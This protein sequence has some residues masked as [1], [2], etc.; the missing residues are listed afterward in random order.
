MT[1]SPLPSCKVFSFSRQLAPGQDAPQNVNVLWT[2]PCDFAVDANV[3]PAGRV[4]DADTLQTT[5]TEIAVVIDS[6]WPAGRGAFSV[7]V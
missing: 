4:A 7:T 6:V 2:S 5:V 3:S 1:P